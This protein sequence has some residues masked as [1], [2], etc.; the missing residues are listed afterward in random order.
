MLRGAAT[1]AQVTHRQRL[2]LYAVAVLV[3]AFLILPTLLVI[4]MSF[5]DLRYLTFPP[6]AWSLRW[7]RAYVSSVEWRDATWIS[8]QAAFWTMVVSTVT[9]T[10]AAYGLNGTL[11][12][13]R[14]VQIVLVLPIMIPVI[15]I[16]VGVFIFFAPLRLNN[17]IP[18]LVLAHSTLAIPLVVISVTA[19]LKSFDMQPGDGRPKH[20]CEP[21]S[22]LYHGDHAANPLLDDLR[23]AP[24]LHHLA[25]RGRDL[26][27][28]VGRRERDLN[29]TN[30]PRAARRDRSHHRRHLFAADPRVN[31]F[32]RR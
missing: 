28:R 17:S 6:P 11:S 14:S 22:R 20:G 4:P 8:F 29:E 2:W 16:A 19:G 31:S 27:P 15:L 10:M 12:R 7:Y 13:A 3:V 24:S 23:R 18:G 9:G 25:R 26:S 1:A 5:S 21:A 30:V 32:A